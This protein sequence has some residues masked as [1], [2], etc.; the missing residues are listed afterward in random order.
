MFPQ[1]DLSEKKRVNFRQTNV[2]FCFAYNRNY[3]FSSTPPKLVIDFLR[4]RDTFRTKSVDIVKDF[5]EKGFHNNGKLVEDLCL[6]Q[7]FFI[8][9]CP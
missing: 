9:H 5:V 6:K 4:E 1:A 7:N 8:F 3:H 2:C